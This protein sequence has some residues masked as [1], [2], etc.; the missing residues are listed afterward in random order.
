MKL[1]EGK[2]AL[3]T[4]GARGIGAAVSG[5][6]AA[7]GAA[8]IVIADVDF[9]KACITADEITAETGCTTLPIKVDISNESDVNNLLEA[10][11][12]RFGTLDI[13]VNNA[14][15]CR[16]VPMDELSME[17]WDRTMDINLKGTFLCSRA[18]LKIMRGRKSGRIV[19]VASQAGKN[20]GI[21][22]NP[23]YAASKAAVICLT[24]S[25][26]KASAPYNITVNSVAPG[27]IATDM[28]RDFGYDSAAV[29]LGRIGSAEEVADVILFLASDLSR[30]VTGA[31]I[32]I[33]GGM[34]MI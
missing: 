2:I 3:V 25:L 29:P 26:A 15:I 31:C 10:T 19:N 17:Q 22:V 34:T 21:M 13:L 9:D 18:A 14:G 12:K 4:G 11:I 33:N 5:R 6:F 16:I 32:D 27:F 23:D 20:G 28:T 30:Y 8:G 24:K 1:T 7:E